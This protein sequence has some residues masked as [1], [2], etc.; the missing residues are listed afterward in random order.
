[1]GDFLIGTGLFLLL[2]AGIALFL[3][4]F[5]KRDWVFTF[6]EPGT[7]KVVLFNGTYRKTIFNFPEHGID[8]EGAIRNLKDVEEN[9]LGEY[10]KQMARFGGLRFIGIPP[11][12]SLFEYTLRWSVIW[13]SVA[14]LGKAMAQ[15]KIDGVVA[16]DGRLLQRAENVRQ[17]YL[18]ATPYGLLLPKAEDHGK[19]AIDVILLT[20][21]VVRN[22][23]KA[24]FRVSNWWNSVSDSLV[25]E[26][27]PWIASLPWEELKEIKGDL[28]VED[29]GE[30]E[31]HR[32]K[33]VKDLIKF[34]LDEWGV[35]ILSIR[36]DE[37]V[38]PKEIAEIATKR[39]QAEQEA[40]A[41]RARAK[42]EADA[43]NTVA[44]AEKGRIVA[45]MGAAKDLG[46]EGVAMKIAEDMAK[47]GKTVFAVGPMIEAARGILG[48]KG[49]N[50]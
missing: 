38:L 5:A 21:A 48:K 46:D 27:R 9:R 4:G 23:S 41:V 15:E 18:K 37:I 31:A 3:F 45:V 8:K 10:D 39:Y 43:I 30:E 34:M 32:P 25:A 17:F 28:L 35:E 13:R 36:I 44:A 2:A 11:F 26:L 42:G 6:V 22:P 19:I 16:A 47:G 20:M 49:E 14:D 7:A 24:A 33:K 29:Q 1:M 12:F 40:E 50:G